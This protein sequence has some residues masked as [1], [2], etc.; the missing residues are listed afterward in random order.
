MQRKRRTWTGIDAGGG[1]SIALG[2]DG[3]V[4]MAGAYHRAEYICLFPRVVLQ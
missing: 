4:L 2:A 1:Y 3:T